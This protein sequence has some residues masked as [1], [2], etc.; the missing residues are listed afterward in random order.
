MREASHK[1][2]QSC[3]EKIKNSLGPHLRSIVGCWAA[4]MCDPYGSAASAAQAAFSAALTP[5]KQTDALKF[6]FKAIVSVSCILLSCMYH[7]P[8]NL[9][10]ATVSSLLAL[11]SKEYK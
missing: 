7:K 6:G 8:V 2:L 4:G 9:W 11:I 3:V 1:A 10:T 5:A